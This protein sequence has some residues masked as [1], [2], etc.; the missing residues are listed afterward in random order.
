[1]SL[2]ETVIATPRGRFGIRTATPPDP[3]AARAPSTVLCVHGF[4]SLDDFSLD[5]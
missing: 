5:K 2:T 4:E 1:M 3:G